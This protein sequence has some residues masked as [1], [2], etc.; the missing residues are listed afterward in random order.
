M[1]LEI[2]GIAKELREKSLKIHKIENL[3]EYLQIGKLSYFSHQSA[4][5]HLTQLLVHPKGVLKLPFLERVSLKLV[6]KK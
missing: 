1:D 4:L 2:K 3:T 6:F 5:Y